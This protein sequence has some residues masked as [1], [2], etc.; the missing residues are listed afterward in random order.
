MSKHV[1]LE[2]AGKTVRQPPISSFAR[3]G[4]KAKV[5]FWE[6]LN[7]TI[8]PSA[9]GRL[10]M[11]Q[12]QY[13]GEEEAFYEARIYAYRTFGRHRDHRDSRGDPIPSFRSGEVGG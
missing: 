12:V 1:Q 9:F 8:F 4:K 5:K 7:P 2:G 11:R 3:K 6:N 13:S 10:I